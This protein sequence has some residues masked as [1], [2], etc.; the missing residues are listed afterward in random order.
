MATTKTGPRGL[1]IRKLADKSEGTRVSGHDTMTGART[2]VNPETQQPEPWPLLGI[3]IEGDTPQKCVVPVSWVARGVEEGWLELEEPQP[4]H[5]PGG[6]SANPWAVTHTF[7]QAKT[8]VLKCIDGDVRYTVTR[9]PD[10][11]VADDLG[12]KVTDEIYANGDTDVHWSY[13]L[14]LEA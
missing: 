4:V 13:E 5:R 11:Y 8:L 3:R 7:I 12:A 9:Q 1:Q 2:L 10:K 6:P 14:E